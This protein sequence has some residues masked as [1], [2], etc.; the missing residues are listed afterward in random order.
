MPSSPTSEA[1]RAANARYWRRNVTLTLVLLALWFA[2][3]LGCGVLLAEPLNETKIGGF[4]LGFWFAQQ[5]AI[6]IFVI[7]ILIYAVVMTRLDRNHREELAS[8]REQNGS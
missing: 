7:L 6:I 8:L 2:G 3:G 4:P 5:G 1:V